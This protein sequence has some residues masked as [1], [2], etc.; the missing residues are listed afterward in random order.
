M[1]SQQEA[2]CAFDKWPHNTTVFHI[3]IDE[4]YS[5]CSFNCN[6]TMSKTKVT[7]QSQKFLELITISVGTRKNLQSYISDVQQLLRQGEMLN[8]CTLKL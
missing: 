1:V 3:P 2:G 4:W 5:N 7:E 8:V 6:I